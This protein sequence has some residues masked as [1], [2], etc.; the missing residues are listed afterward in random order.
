MDFAENH[1]GGFF[2]EHLLM[3]MR[4]ESAIA[5]ACEE[6]WQL[7]TRKSEKTSFCQKLG[8]K[9]TQLLNSSSP[10]HK[11]GLSFTWKLTPP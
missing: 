11:F 6:I 7:Q 1:A 3:K 5:N 4:E 8:Q 2:S 9:A 10:N